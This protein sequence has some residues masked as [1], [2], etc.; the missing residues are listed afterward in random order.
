MEEKITIELESKIDLMLILGALAKA[1]Q[2]YG[3]VDPRY[4]D[5]RK[6]LNQQAIK[7]SPEIENV[8]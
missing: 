7:L 3:I 5:L 2:V 6:R 4:T 1:Q 8:E